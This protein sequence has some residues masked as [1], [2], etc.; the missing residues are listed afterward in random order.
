MQLPSEA[1]WEEP[2]HPINAPIIYAICPHKTNPSPVSGS[3]DGLG[4]LIK[5]RPL[6]GLI[7]SY[8]SVNSLQPSRLQAPLTPSSPASSSSPGSLFYALST[9]WTRFTQRRPTPKSSVISWE[10]R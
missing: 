8:W 3:P 7:L 4:G 5:A 9:S 10:N 2:L 1:L 6:A